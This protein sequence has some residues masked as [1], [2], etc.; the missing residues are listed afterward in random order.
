MSPLVVAKSVF[1]KQN[2]FYK[3]RWDNLTQINIM[4]TYE[5]IKNIP[6]PL[7]SLTDNTS[8]CANVTNYIN[9]YYRMLIKA[10]ERVANVNIQISKSI[11]Y[12]FWWDEEL[13]I[14]KRNSINA[15]NQQFLDGKPSSGPV[16][17]VTNTEKLQYKNKIQ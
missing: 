1:S 12:K 5:E 11:F 9:A 16:F 13:I 14:I 17:V 2:D 7:H 10:L 15:H 8:N 3:L 4:T 6:V